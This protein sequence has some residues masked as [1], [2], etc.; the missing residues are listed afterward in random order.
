MHEI[1]HESTPLRRLI[2][3]VLSVLFGVRL[4]RE[5]ML[6]KI[7]GASE[8]QAGGESLASALRAKS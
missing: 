2:N 4:V 3:R 1:R 7:Q 8:Q 5:H 6:A